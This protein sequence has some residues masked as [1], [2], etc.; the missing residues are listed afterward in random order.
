MILFESSNGI[1]FELTTYKKRC[2][3]AVKSGAYNCRIYRF[4]NVPFFESPYMSWENLNCCNGWSYDESYLLTAVQE[5][6]K[7]C[8]GITFNDAESVREYCDNL[9][10]EYLFYEYEPRKNAIGYWYSVDVFRKG[11]LSDYYSID[12]VLAAYEKHDA[13]YLVD[14]D[15]V[16]NI[17]SRPI[18]DLIN[19]S[20]EFDYGK[21]SYG[22][23]IYTED[24]IIT[25]LLLGY[26]LESTASLINGY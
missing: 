5:G 16:K 7:L 20:V 6:K 9:S 10:D 17:A 24:T 22:Q 4:N 26:P 11:C 3:V 14:N 15:M 23:A 18:L 13:L 21:Y 25:G 8:A 12:D 19:G 2:K 1:V